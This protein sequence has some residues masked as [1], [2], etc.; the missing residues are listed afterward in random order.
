MLR[1]SASSA[2]N[3]V[4]TLLGSKMTP[5]KPSNVSWNDLKMAKNH[6]TTSSG[7]PEGPQ[8]STKSVRKRNQNLVWSQ[9]G[10][11]I[12]YVIVVVLLWS[13]PSSLLE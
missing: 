6:P 12:N 7:A 3:A 8:A 4:K 11:D 5:A 9:F 13:E 1:K 2:Q 10:D